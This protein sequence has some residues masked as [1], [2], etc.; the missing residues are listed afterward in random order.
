MNTDQ[1]EDDLDF[2]VFNASENLFR[3]IPTVLG[4][5]SGWSRFHKPTGDCERGQI[6]T[7]LGRS[8]ESTLEISVEDGSIAA[9][10]GLAGFRNGFLKVWE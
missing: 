1:N 9:G 3:T 4:T 2:V 5:R 7:V 10:L 6:P 8:G